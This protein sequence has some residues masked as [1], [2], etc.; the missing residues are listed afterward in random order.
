L[1]IEIITD[2]IIESTIKQTDIIIAIEIITDT[3]IESTIKQTDI[4][5]AKCI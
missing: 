3:I 2:T 5:I 1:K 4:I